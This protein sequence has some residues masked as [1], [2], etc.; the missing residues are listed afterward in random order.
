[1]EEVAGKGAEIVGWVEAVETQ[2]DYLVN[3]AERVSSTAARALVE[4]IP[5]DQAVLDR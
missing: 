3:D 1:L 5:N 2:V 4:V